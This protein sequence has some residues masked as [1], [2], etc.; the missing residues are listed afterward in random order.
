MPTVSKKSRAAKKRIENQSR[1]R[2]LFGPRYHATECLETNVV[3]MEEVDS[4]SDAVDWRRELELN[5]FNMRESDEVDEDED[6]GEFEEVEFVL[7]DSVQSNPMKTVNDSL[8]WNCHA[9]DRIHLPGESKRNKRLCVNFVKKVLQNQ[10][11]ITVVLN[12]YYP[13]NQTS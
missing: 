6:D 1:L 3:V 2:G 4:E 11:L 7:Q 12:D 13:S 5:I 10:L 9:L 8:K